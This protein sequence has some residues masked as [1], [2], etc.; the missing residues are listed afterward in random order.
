MQPKTGIKID[1]SFN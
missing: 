1:K